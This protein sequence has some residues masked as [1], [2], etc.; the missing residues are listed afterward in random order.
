[1][2]ESAEYKTAREDYDRLEKALAAFVEKGKSGES[3][4]EQAHGFVWL[5]RRK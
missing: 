3:G 4:P 1:M 5:F 2:N